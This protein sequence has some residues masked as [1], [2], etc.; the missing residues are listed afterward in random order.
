M[1]SGSGK[2]LQHEIKDGN[3]VTLRKGNEWG[4]GHGN[5]LI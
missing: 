2:K 4:S 5:D 1:F 3:G